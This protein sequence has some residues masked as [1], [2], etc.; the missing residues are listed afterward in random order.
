MGEWEAGKEK[1]N[2]S[3]AIKNIRPARGEKV[4]FKSGYS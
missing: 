1:R 2:P 3:L 4:V